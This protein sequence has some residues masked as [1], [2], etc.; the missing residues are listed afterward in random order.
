[1]T[2]W[3]L[4]A[5]NV[6]K[7]DQLSITIG[8]NNPY[9]LNNS[10]KKIGYKTYAYHNYYG[11]FYSRDD[12]FEADGYDK[13]AFCG[14]VVKNCDSFRASDLEMMKN[15]V[16]NYIKDDNFFAY[17]I[18]V[19]GH[20]NYFYNSN[21]I[22]QR[23]YSSV[24]NLDYSSQLKT[25]IAAN[26]ELDK[27]LEYLL[28]IL[29]EKGKLEDTVIVITPDH[30]P[31]YFTN[32]ELNEIDIE[33]RTDKFLMHHENLIIW[34]PSIPEIEV[35]KYVSNIDVL[36][37]LLN[38][39][40]ITYDSRLF[41]GQ[42]ALS[43]GFGTVILSD[44]SWINN[45]GKYNSVTNTFNASIKVDNNYLEKMNNTVNTYFNISNLIQEKSYY[46]YLF[47]SLEK[48]KENDMNETNKGQ[49]IV[50]VTE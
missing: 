27:A 23:N 19:S 10:L 39:F 21:T 26:I 24:K 18:T 42:D 3:S 35:N 33:D 45:N 13:Y 38:L 40:G 43:E 17:Y 49:E 20:G 8:N 9:R 11:Y 5:A 25:Y 29:D 7:Y 37:T 22:A 32:N 30:Y 47:E 14:T 6:A 16:N 15:T 1:M 2:E 46:T 34:N 36:P 41:I 50:Q 48:M 12:Y 4:L 31:Y 28:K 44:Q